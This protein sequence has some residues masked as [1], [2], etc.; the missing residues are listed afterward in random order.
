[1]PYRTAFNLL[2][3]PFS[4]EIEPHAL[5][6]F[7]AFKQCQARLDFLRRE[8]GAAAITGDIGI[9]KTTSVR[10]FL[11][12]LAPSN[13]Q[14]LYGAVSSVQ[15][16]LRSVIEGW[17]E[18]LGERVPF[19]NLSVSMRL[20][21][22]ALLAV[23]E[24]GRLPF[25]VL[26]EAHQLDNRSLLQLKTLLNYDMDSRL[27]LAMLLVGGPTLARHLAFHGVQELRQRLL[28]V[29]PLQGLTR[30]EMAPYLEARLKH[31]GCDRLLFP[32]DVVDEL[33][34]HTQGFA[35]PVNQMASLCLIAAATTGKHQIDSQCIRQALA[36]MGL[37]EENRL[38]HLG[39]TPGTN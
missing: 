33:Y 15:A 23:Y 5:F 35:R 19:N 24:K 3:P 31:A 38:E 1:M 6:P 2:R 9:G 16:T 25:I 27:P 13:Y 30:A 22:E 29:Y 39:F 26:D 34:R 37:S 21:H 20:F 17:L 18:E 4:P 14:V 28:Y 36:E 10:A 8:R 7:E 12:Q 32:P 11:R